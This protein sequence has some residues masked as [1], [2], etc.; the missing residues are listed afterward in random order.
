MKSLSASALS[1]STLF[2]S[3]LLISALFF[4]PLSSK[5]E[6]ANKELQEARLLIKT[7]AGELT[8]VLQ[9]AMK[10]GGP[11]KALD[12][13]RVQA[14]PISDK[15]ALS[16]GWTIGRTSLKVRNVDNEPDQWESKTLLR[17]EQRKAA[18]ENLKTME[19]SEVLTEQGELVLRYM[20]PIPTSGLC[21]TC[22][23]GSLSDEISKKVTL[24]YPYDKATGFKVGDIRGAFSLQ[25]RL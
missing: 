8:S 18:G 25:K 24:L 5:A 7:F 13:C 19:H 2:T 23:G 11:V 17:F 4:V 16:S 3:A 21:I 22:H 10:V 15:V 20:K 14:G 12:V 9:H 1:T 6:T